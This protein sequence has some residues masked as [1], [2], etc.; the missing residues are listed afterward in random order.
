MHEP[1]TTPTTEPFLESRMR[2]AMNRLIAATRPEHSLRPRLSVILGASGD[3]FYFAN[4]DVLS[5]CSCLDPDLDK[6]VETAI[7]AYV[8][9]HSEHAKLAQDADRLGYTL[10]PKND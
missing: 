7:A 4:M 6:A 5:E 8:A 9:V 10:V 1:N 2:L 3:V